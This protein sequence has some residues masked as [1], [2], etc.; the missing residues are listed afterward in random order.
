MDSD[1]DGE[2][3]HA[4][5]IG[6][7][8]ADGRYRAGIVGVGLRPGLGNVNLH[9][10][11][12]VVYVQLVNVGGDGHG[13]HIIQGNGGLPRLARALPLLQPHHNH[14]AGNLRGHVIVRPLLLS[15]GDL[16]LGLGNFVL[17]LGN[18]PFHRLHLLLQ[19]RAVHGKEQR[20][21]G[22]RFVVRDIDSGQLPAHLRHNVFAGVV[23]QGPLHRWIKL[24][25]GVG[26]QVA[27]AAHSF[28]KRAG[29]FHGHGH[30]EAAGTLCGNPVHLFDLR[31]GPLKGAHQAGHGNACLHTHM[32]LILIGVAEILGQGHLAVIH[33]GGQPGS[34]VYTVS[35]LC[36]HIGDPP[37]K[38]RGDRQSR[39]AFVQLGQLALGVGQSVLQFGNLV[40]VGL[41]LFIQLGGIL[42]I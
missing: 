34:R 17:G 16:L 8:V 10:H 20:A 7:L 26:H 25:S 27:R 32:D 18:A 29:I 11:G 3:G 21:F 4:V 35:H 30:R 14:L 28:G 41:D 39:H 12:D 15:L 22:Y 2:I 13:V 5:G 19:V 23:L 24:L 1:G 9:T 37:G 31:Y 6:G 42:R 38:R 36:G 33:Q 40:L